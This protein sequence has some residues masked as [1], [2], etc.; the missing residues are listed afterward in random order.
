MPI[1]RDRLLTYLNKDGYNVVRRPRGGISPL[2]LIGQTGSNPEWLGGLKTIWSSEIP[3][4]KAGAEQPVA[5][6]SLDER[7]FYT[8]DLNFSV[9]S[10]LLDHILQ[11]LGASLPSLGFALNRRSRFSFKINEPKSVGVAPL[12][13][14]NFLKAGDLAVA[15]PF[16]RRYFTGNEARAFVISEILRSCSV[17][18]TADRD[19]NTMASIQAVAVQDLLKADGALKA[20]NVSSEAI[21]FEGRQPV[22]FGFKAFEIVYLNGRW[23]VDRLD[24][25]GAL[26]LLG[27]GTGDEGVPEPKVLQQGQPLVI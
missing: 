1:C 22:V 5:G 25:D 26:A 10:E 21:T 12:E 4:P 9:G 7:S 27:A 3:V 20:S 11:G 23:N 17:T 16:V 14:G 18:L 24:P 19:K 13:I 2:D 6:V 15:N 8:A